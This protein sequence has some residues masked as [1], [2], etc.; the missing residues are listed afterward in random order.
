LRKFLLENKINKIFQILREKI[1]WWHL[2]I[3]TI[4]TP[5]FF[6]GLWFL[7][8]ILA[9]AHFGEGDKSRFF[10][11]Y[12]GKAIIIAAWLSIELI[13]YRLTKDRIKNNCPSEAKSFIINSIL[14]LIIFIVAMSTLKH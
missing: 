12:I 8:F 9:W 1:S 6:F 2:I 3:T 5:A 7:L 13:L 11:P 14:V 4:I 10:S